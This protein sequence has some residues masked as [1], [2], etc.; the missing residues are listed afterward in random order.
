MTRKFA[1][2]EGKP[3]V[4]SDLTGPVSGHLLMNCV[5]CSTPV[6][7]G[8]RFRHSCGSMVSDAEGQAAATA[9]MDQSAFA[10]MERMLRDETRGEYS[11]GKMLGR[12]GKL[13]WYAMKYLEGALARGRAA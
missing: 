13:F 9:A 8:A 7:D 11:V 12:G 5:H 3:D 1:E 6:G 4:Q 2:Q 10:H